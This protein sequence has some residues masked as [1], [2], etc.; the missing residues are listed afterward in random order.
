MAYGL[1]SGF[2]GS[3]SEMIALPDSTLD[4]I[5]DLARC[6]LGKAATIYVVEREVAVPFA[7]SPRRLGRGK[8]IPLGVFLRQPE[9]PFHDELI[10]DL[11][12]NPGL[13]EITSIH[14][15]NSVI[16]FLVTEKANPAEATTPHQAQ[17]LRCMADIAA[18]VLMLE[19]SLA[20]IARCSMAS[21]ELGKY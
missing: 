21:L 14:G 17:A 15:D 12:F 5:C 3:L 19:C 8:A 4:K 6:E 18:R 7:R 11:G 9:K 16:G 10:A 2:K 20:S 1:E 13:C